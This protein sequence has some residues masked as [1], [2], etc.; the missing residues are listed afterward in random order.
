MAGRPLISPLEKIRACLSREFS[1]LFMDLADETPF[2]ARH[3]GAREGGG[4]YSLTLVSA[5]F[6]GLSLLDR[7]RAVYAALG[8]LMSGDIHALSVKAFS[9]HEW[10]SQSGRS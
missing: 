1:P 2:H 5:R 6:D 10:K 4:H 3:P 7:H 9:P 8:G